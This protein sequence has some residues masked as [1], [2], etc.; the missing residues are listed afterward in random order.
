MKVAAA[1]LAVVFLALA[2][3]DVAP[4][5]AL[6]RS[7]DRAAIEALLDRRAAAIRNAD[8]GEFLATIAGD[9][10]FVRRQQRLFGG[11][12]DVPLADYELTV[13][14]DALGDLARP[15]DLEHYDAE[16]V[17]IPLVQERYRLDGFDRHDAVE[18]AYFTFV[19]RDGRWAIVADDDLD[20]L[21]FHTVRHPWDFGRVTAT[22]VDRGALPMLVIEGAR[23]KCPDLPPGVIDESATWAGRVDAFWTP[24]WDRRLVLVVP[25]TKRELQRALQATFDPSKFIAFAYSTVDSLGGLRYAGHRIF[26]NPP[27]FNGR[28]VED[29]TTIMAHELL[30]VASRDVSGPFIPLFVEE[31]LG[32]TVAYTDPVRGLAFFDS[33]VASGG[34][35]ETL[36]PDFTFA[37][38]DAD[39]IYQS[40]QEGQS[41]VRFLASRWGQEA[42]TRFYIELGRRVYAPGVARWHV[43]DA[44]RERIGVGLERFEQLW[45]DSIP[46]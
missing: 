40:Y 39:S 14:W 42:L 32:D 17:S 37:I 23:D 29:T 21:G 31:G 20:G 5:A 11:F 9:R 45:A 2:T 33:I 10:A 24:R 36:P 30:H 46:G 43:D 12:L 6:A 4:A 22:R 35:D 26:I 16:A 1:T 8:R 28:P 18:D 44:M 27:V 15:S 41:A 7:D 13:R 25:C 3:L 34:F 19:K 38:G